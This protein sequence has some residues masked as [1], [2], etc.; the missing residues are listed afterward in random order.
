M[1]L[2]K[3]LAENEIFDGRYILLEKI[4]SDGNLTYWRCFDEAIEREVVLFIVPLSTSDV[5]DA[6]TNIKIT[7][8]L[9]HPHIIPIYD[10]RETGEYLYAVQFY[11]VNR[12]ILEYLEQ[13]QSEKLSIES[14]LRLTRQLAR[15]IDYIHTK[16]TVHYHIR[17]EVIL[18][19]K[20]LNLYLT[21]FHVPRTREK[22]IKKCGV[23]EY[24]APE[25][26]TGQL[27]AS[28]DIYAFGITLFQL[29]AHQP[30]FAI[31]KEKP[32]LGSL[33][34]RQ[35]HKDP[36]EQLPSVRQFRPELPI[37]IDQV[38][39]RL[40]S[41]D[42]QLRYVNASAA[43]E[44]LTRVFYSGQSSI[45]GRVFIS[46]A[47]KDKDYV[48]RLAT[49]LRRGGVDIWIAQDIQPGSNWDD[50]IESALNGS[51]M[52]ILVVTEASMSS[53]YVNHEWSYFRGRGKPVYPIIPQAPIPT[54]IHP[55][56]KRMQHTIGTDDMLNNVARIVD[57][58]AGGTPTK[59]GDTEIQA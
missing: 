29:F 24:A 55:R 5:E 1:S 28:C 8:G 47:H 30:P 43:A 3:Q 32:H 37:G 7:A 35:Q 50:A 22:L 18:L 20:E 27:S 46:Y 6:R 44:Y 13:P 39:G 58:L 53:E 15:A 49:E 56:L 21:E 26:F 14:I 23:V 57:V 31:N 9:Q 52:M 34:W 59:L 25:Q 54:N 45:K 51:D 48:H 38:L 2:Q 16:E 42:P 17:P 33:G 4:W 12:S 36:D 40:T 11:A 19:D 10:L 41:K